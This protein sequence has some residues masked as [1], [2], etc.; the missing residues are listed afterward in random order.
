M[1]ELRAAGVHTLQGPAVVAVL[2]RELGQRLPGRLVAV[3]VHRVDPQGGLVT[4]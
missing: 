1:L 4:H 2:Q 3:D